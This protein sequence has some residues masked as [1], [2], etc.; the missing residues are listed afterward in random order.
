MQMSRRFGESVISHKYMNCLLDYSLRGKVEHLVRMR[1]RLDD[2]S[3]FLEVRL[4]ELH[5]LIKQNKEN[6]S[7]RRSALPTAVTPLS[8]ALL[9]GL[10]EGMVGTSSSG[11]TASAPSST[12][13]S[14]PPATHSAPL[15]ASDKKESSSITATA[16]SAAKV[17]SSNS[18]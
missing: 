12:K 5:L 1:E 18:S 16:P 15:S 7:K 14:E 4:A 8:P 17:N 11:A 13:I 10:A 2:H 3:R 9:Q 6:E